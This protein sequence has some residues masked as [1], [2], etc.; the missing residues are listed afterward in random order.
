MSDFT[1]V[2]LDFVSRATCRRGGRLLIALAAII[3]WSAPAAAANC[4]KEDKAAA[5]AELVRFSSSAA[6]VDAAVAAHLPWG[7][8]AETSPTTN[9]ITLVQADYVIRYD[10]DL[11]VPLWTAERIE[12][13]RLDD[14]VDRED[15]FRGDPRL[16]DETSSQKPDYS[17]PVYDQGHMMPFADQRYSKMSGHNS[18]VMTNMAPQNCQLNRGI[19]Q[20]LEQISRR[21]ADQH[22]QLYVVAGSVFDRDGDGMRDPDSAA[23]HMKSNNGKKRVAIPSAFYKIV[24]FR[25]PDGSVE[26]VS[27]LFPHDDSNPTGA[28]ALTYLNAHVTDIATLER[29][30]GLDLFP[31]AMKVIE[32]RTLWPFEGYRPSSLCHNPKPTPTPTP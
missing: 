25:K 6:E 10:K 21:W 22:D 29:L 32:S 18:F 30:A 20:I 8:P 3:S 13:K 23:A 1:F 2:R 9:E 5:D 16:D 24:A 28:A 26:T 27:V 19:W 4:S 12:G 17:E 11:R 7:V 15:C 31:Q 14:E